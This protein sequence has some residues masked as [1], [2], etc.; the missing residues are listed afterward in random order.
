M[1]LPLT[2]RVWIPLQLFKLNFKIQQANMS[3]RIPQSFD[4]FLVLDFEA[5]CDNKKKI[6]PQTEVDDGE[7]FPV[8][9]Q[10]FDKWMKEDVGLGKQFLFITCGDWDLKTMLPSQCALENLQVPQYCKK[11]LN[12]K[13][14]Y[15]VMTGE[16]NKGMIS[17][18]RGLQLSHTGHLH[19]G[20]D[21]C[22]NIAIIL[23]ALANRGCKFLPTMSIS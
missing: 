16:Y 9:L 8:V 14:S 23:R 2:S 4:Y 18:M 3:T 20:F 21:D 12:I 19:R 5:T 22:L 6:E 11:W 1:R 15:A 7:L 10:E 17:M 13:K